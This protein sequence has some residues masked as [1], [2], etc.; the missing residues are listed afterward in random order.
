MT[1]ASFA[2]D[3]DVAAEHIEAGALLV[4]LVAT[5]FGQNEPGLAASAPRLLAFIADGLLGR[6]EIL[7]CAA[8]DAPEPEAGA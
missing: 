1:R 3:I 2:A 7:R 4:R 8:E 5:R 6:A